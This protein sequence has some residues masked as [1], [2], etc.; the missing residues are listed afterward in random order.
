MSMRM[1]KIWRSIPSKT[2]NTKICNINLRNQIR[3]REIIMQMRSMRNVKK[4]L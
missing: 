4:I 3:T 1:R 2:S